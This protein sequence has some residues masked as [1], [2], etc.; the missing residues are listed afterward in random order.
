MP[1][2]SR[3]GDRSECP[4]DAHGCPECPHAAAGAAYMGAPDV[5]V[6]GR[7]AVRVADM[8]WH[9]SCCGS[10]TWHAANGSK[11]VLING[12]P[13]HRKGDRVSHCGGVGRMLDGSD[14][15]LVGER[16]GPPVEEGP[17]AYDQAFVLRD[18]GTGTLL[19]NWLYRIVRDDGRVV[20]GRTDARGR[21]A[22]V[23]GEHPETLRIDVLGPGF[24]SGSGCDD[25][26]D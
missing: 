10:N 20:W 2:Q 22:L 17:K 12:R 14:N 21:T 23:G 24:G 15:V 18:R 9:A 4:A 8:G 7:A 26:H 6:N 19:A 16:E 25:D 13:A 11:T 5:L 3:V 1:P